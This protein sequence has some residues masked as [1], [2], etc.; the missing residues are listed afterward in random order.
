MKGIASDKTFIN[1]FKSYIIVLIIPLVF[2]IIISSFIAKALYHELVELGNYS[3]YL[4]QSET[5][6]TLG[7]ILSDAS[8]LASHSTLRQTIFFDDEKSTIH[9]QR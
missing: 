8:Q 3:T 4:V 5:D 7:L 6:N 9:Q 2:G 1:I